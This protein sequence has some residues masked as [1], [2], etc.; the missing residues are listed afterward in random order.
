MSKKYPYPTIGR[1]VLLCLSAHM[2]EEINRLRT[3]P[4]SIAERIQN[5][6]WPR[7]AQA[8]VGN[9]A[10]EGDEVP[11]TVVG[12][13]GETCINAHA[14]LDGNDTYWATSV[15]R[16]ETGEPEPHRWRWMHYQVQQVNPPEPVLGT[17]DANAGAAVVGDVAEA[18][19]GAS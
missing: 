19:G 3:S 7:G 13:H 6:Q 14:F 10:K 11:A 18:E 15:T 8:H 1:M 2:A 12:V 5:D 17:V 16:S 4:Q 9:W